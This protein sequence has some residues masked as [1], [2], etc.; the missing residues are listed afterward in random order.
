M[1]VLAK[2]VRQSVDENGEVTGN[3]HEN[4][5]LNTLIYGC[6]F[7]DGTIKE[8]VANIIDGN[9]FNESDPDGYQDR[10]VHTLVDRKRSGGAMQKG[11]G[12]ISTK[13]GQK[14][15]RKTTVG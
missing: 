15:M 7:S 6:K 1:N 12:H 4:P 5:M 2:V 10:N 13:S 8:C 3:F 11:N 9:I 14:R